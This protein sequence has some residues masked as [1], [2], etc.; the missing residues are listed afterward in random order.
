MELKKPWIDLDGYINTRSK[1]ALYEAELALDF[2]RQ[3]LIRN[4]A[5]K[6][7]QAWKAV[8]ALLAAKE[9]ERIRGKYPGEKRLKTG[10][11]IAEAYWII[12]F[13]P[14]TRLREVARLLAESI[15]MEVYFATEIA[16]SL[17]EYQY[18]GP[19]KELIFSR[20]RTDEEAARDI[21]LLI[22]LVRK[23]SQ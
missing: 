21:S 17:H 13:M 1:E 7:F 2:L 20:Y 22:N 16:L 15:G 18:N 4:A 6:A 23:Y 3:G 8:L 11:K 9:E 5:G 10:K 12:A 19:D 14:T